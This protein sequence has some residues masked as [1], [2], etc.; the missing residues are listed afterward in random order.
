MPPPRPKH[1]RLA[2]TC[3]FVLFL[4]AALPSA[5][6]QTAAA[7]SPA[8]ADA[9]L[10]AYDV[11]SI[12][13]NNSGSRSSSSSSNN[14]RLSATNISLK[15]LLQQVYAIK[16]NL[17]S[18]IPGPVDSARFDI[19]AK[20]ADPNPATLKKMTP[21]QSRQMLLPLLSDRFQLKTHIE[22]KTLPSMNSC[23]PK[24][25]RSSSRPRIRRPRTET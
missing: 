5:H 3:L 6:S 19:E 2:A 10:I 16:E 7:P 17:I 4:V 12:K 21:E 20:V 11:I 9:T 18:G 1:P 24:E 13:P 25:A 22:V 23:S 15:Q 8:T 14:G